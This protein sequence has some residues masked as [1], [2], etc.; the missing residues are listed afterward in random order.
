MKP[1]TREI[2]NEE[3]WRSVV[4]LAI[5]LFGWSLI[6]TSTDV[7]AASAL[8]ALGLPLLTAAVLAALMVGIRLATGL[9]LKAKTEGSQLL[10]L[11]VGS[12][13]GGFVVLYDVL[14]NGRGPLIIL[15]YAVAV[16]FGVLIWRVARR[17]QSTV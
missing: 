14:V 5:G 2:I 12:V 11:I 9:E 15:G 10:W 1:D 16:G 8:T 4:W 6:L 3:L 17:Q 7:L 13:L